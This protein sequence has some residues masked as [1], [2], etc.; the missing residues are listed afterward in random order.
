VIDTVFTL[1]MLPLEFQVKIYCPA[2]DSLVDSD[3]MEDIPLLLGAI[4]LDPDCLPETCTEKILT[5]NPIPLSPVITMF[6][7]NT[8]PALENHQP[9]HAKNPALTEMT[10]PPKRNN[11]RDPNPIPSAKAFRPSKLKS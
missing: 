4:G 5:V 10:M 3:V 8:D 2:A 7:E 6:L 9:P 1:V 11:T